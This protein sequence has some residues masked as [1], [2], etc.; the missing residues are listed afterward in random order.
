MNPYGSYGPFCSSVGKIRRKRARDEPLWVMWTILFV[1][2]SGFML[3]KFVEKELETNPYGSNGPFCSS[4]VLG[5][6]CVV[7]SEFDSLCMHNKINKAIFLWAGVFIPFC[8]FLLLNRPGDSRRGRRWL[9]PDRKCRGHR[10]Y[11]HCPIRYCYSCDGR[12]RCH[13]RRRVPRRSRARPR[14][15]DRTPGRRRRP[16]REVGASS[17][18]TPRTVCRRCRCLPGRNWAG[19]NAAGG[20]RRCW[21]GSSR[22]STWSRRSRWVGRASDKRSTKR[23]NRLINQSI[24]RKPTN[25]S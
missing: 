23:K 8:L 5:L 4:V 2:C 11:C 17:A 18:P 1:C 16:G 20:G 15:A 13:R 10:Y 9:Q 6:C 19:D 21:G 7:T 12:R 14:P 25:Q 22:C 24:N 3:E